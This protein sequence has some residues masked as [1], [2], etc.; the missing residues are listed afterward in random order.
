[1]MGKRAA[2]LLVSL[3]LGVT[4]L[5]LC[6]PAFAA[7]SSSSGAPPEPATVTQGLITITFPAGF[8]VFTRNPDTKTDNLDSNAKLLG[9][10]GQSPASFRATMQSSGI[11]F[12]AV[13]G[14]LLTQFSLKTLQTDYTRSV[15]SLS[16][17]DAKAQE[18]ASSQMVSILQ[19]VTG[20]VVTSAQ[21]V[22]Q[23]GGQVFYRAAATV[24]DSGVTYATRQYLT[25]SGGQMVALSCYGGAAAL[26]AAQVAQA[27]AVFAS[28]RVAPA[29]SDQGARRSRT[30]QVILVDAAAAA[31]AF[32]ALYILISFLRD[33][34][35]RDRNEYI[36]R[37]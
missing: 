32:A 36:R 6:L 19:S 16:R 10:L 2:R 13:S 34:R 29:P 22:T 33:F 31:L 25:I 18:Q 7:S 26:T 3:A 15:G 11:L 30:L 28:M 21:R 23:D 8:T 37:P 9:S 35:N 27:D 12:Y 20:S 1:M 24:T 5:M 4:S 17:L 14:D